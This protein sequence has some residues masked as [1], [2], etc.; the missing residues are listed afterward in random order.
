MNSIQ[1]IKPFW[2]DGTRVFDDDRF[3]LSREPFVA[4]ADEIITKLVADI[5]KARKG[6]K[7]FFS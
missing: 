3:G 7:L 4:G 2:H 6:F 1:L 5:P